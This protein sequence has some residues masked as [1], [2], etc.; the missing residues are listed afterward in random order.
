MKQYSVKQL[1][2]LAGVS[3]RTLHLYDEK[4][5]LTPS[6]RT[7]A[8]YRY[9]GEKELLKLQQILFYKELD[10]SLQDI[11]DIINNPEFDVLNA[12]ESHKNALNAR[13]NRISALLETI[14][15]TIFHLKNGGN[16]LKDEDLYAG[17]PK[18]K[19]Q[20]YRNEAIEKWGKNTVEKSEMHLRN[21]SKEGLN[22]LKN[23]FLNIGKQLSDLQNEA[24]DSP[25]VQGLIAQHYDCIC[26][27]WGKKPT[28]EAYIGLGQ[29]YT[30]DERYAMQDSA[31]Q[32]DYAA[33]LSKAMK[34]YAEKHLG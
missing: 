10:F 27:F 5:L 32:P 17:L 20:A 4:G 2:K 28:A 22:T 12:L 18:E 25:T 29:L 21:M 23:R 30:T 9:Y 11:K 3:V 7:E 6:V 26:Q 31:P 33:F 24:P 16:M 13:Q 14:D 15:K 34:F 8:K 1:A 19:A